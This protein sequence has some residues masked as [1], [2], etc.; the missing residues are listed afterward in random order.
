MKSSSVR[1]E[2]SLDKR[3]Y[4]KR[5]YCK[6][7]RTDQRLIVKIREFVLMIRELILKIREL[8]YRPWRT[9]KLKLLCNTDTSLS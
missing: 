4:L 7:Q 6:G 3:S 8:S 2:K 1:S 5:N 9:G